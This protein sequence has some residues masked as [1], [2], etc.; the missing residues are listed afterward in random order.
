MKHPAISELVIQCA[1]ESERLIAEGIG[2]FGTLREFTE[3][4]FRIVWVPSAEVKAFRIAPNWF[5][6]GPKPIGR[7]NVNNLALE[8]CT[9]NSP[10]HRHR[11]GG[12][13]RRI[14]NGSHGQ[15]AAKDGMIESHSILAGSGEQQIGRELHSGILLFARPRCHSVN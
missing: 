15:F 7:R 10:V 3:E 8:P 6:G 2:Y 13:H 9:D 14:A 5:L 11:K 1:V 12:L 4:R